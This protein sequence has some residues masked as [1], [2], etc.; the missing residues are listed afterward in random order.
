MEWPDFALLSFTM[1]LEICPILPVNQMKF[2][3][4]HAC[5]PLEYGCFHV[6]ETDLQAS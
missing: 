3:L 5:L 2:R 6:G 1:Y 4:D